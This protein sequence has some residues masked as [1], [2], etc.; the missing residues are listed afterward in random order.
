MRVQYTQRKKN[1]TVVAAAIVIIAVA[2]AEKIRNVL[3][4]AN[5]FEF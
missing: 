2:I 3:S 1:T 5:I 4:D